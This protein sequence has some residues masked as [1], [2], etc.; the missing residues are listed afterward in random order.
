LEETDRVAVARLEKEKGLTLAR[1][2][3]DVREKEISR[4]FGLE[5]EVERDIYNLETELLMMDREI[6]CREEY[7]SYLDE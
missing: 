7:L 1:L 3:E 2:S 5:N 4:A 6:E